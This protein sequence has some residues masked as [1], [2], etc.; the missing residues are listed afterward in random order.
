MQVLTFSWREALFGKYDVFHVHWPETLV[1]GHSPFKTL[2]KQLLFCLLILRLRVAKRPIVRTLHNLE[3]P[4][5]ISRRQAALLRWAERATT[6]WIL[7]NDATPIAPDHLHAVVLHGHYRDWYSR[8]TASEVTP[9][10]VGFFGRIRRYKNAVGLVRAFSQTTDPGLTLRVA[11]LPSSEELEI[12]LRAAAAD[13]PRIQLEFSFLDD[14]ALVRHVTSTELVVLPY[15][16]MHNSGSA[17]AAL[18]MNRPVLLPDNEV[19]SQLAA[20]VGSEWVIRYP[21]ELEAEHIEG[22]LAQV[23]TIPA[24]SV[25]DLSQRD[26][27]GIAAQHVAAYEKAIATTH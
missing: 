15:P 26:W 1:S 18:S 12:D 9:G 8:F 11:G 6:F 14:A 2:V 24:G 25:P 5:G 21:G 27:P 4:Q 10:L 19:N 22:A 20:E 23:R 17:F 7:L 13:D 16:E 3:L